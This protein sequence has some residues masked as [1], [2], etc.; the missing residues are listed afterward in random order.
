MAA[1]AWGAVPGDEVD[2]IPTFNKTSFKVYSG[3]I[4]VKG[5]FKLNP[6]TE[7]QI[8]YQL[9]CSQRSQSDPLVTWHQGGPGGSSLF[10]AYTEGGY[11][12]VADSGNFVNPHAWNQ[13]ANMLYLES[14]AGSSDPIGFSYCKSGENILTICKFDDKSQA[15]AYAMT[16]MAFYELYPEFKSNDFYITGESYAGQYIPNI[17][18]HMLY[19]VP[20]GSFPSFKGIMVGNG[21]WGGTNTSVDCNGPNS[22]KIDVDLFF[23]K[24]LMSKKLRDAVYTECKFANL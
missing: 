24:G 3:Y 16:M 10:G 6:Y 5:P 17:A 4:T 18:Y 21:C 7:L 8:H 19:E 9:D 22:D 15:E 12:Q 20:A 11:F 13:V 1:A 23:G 2:M 14:P